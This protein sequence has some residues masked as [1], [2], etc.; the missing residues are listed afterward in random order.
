MEYYQYFRLEGPPF[1]PASPDGAVYFSPTHLQGLATLEAGLT[2]E[3][4]G[5]TLLTGEAGIGKTTL[6]Y[7]LLQRDYKRVRIAH[8]D[9]PKLSFLEILRVI[10]TQLNLYSAG[11]TKLDYLKVL[12]HLLELHGKEERIAIVVDESQ[13]LSDDILEELRLLS[14][15][16]QRNDRCLLQLIL[17]GQPE[18]AERLKKPELRQLNQRISSRGVLKPLNT[19][20]AIMYVECRLSVQGSKCSAIFEPRALNHL[21]RRS[22]GI[23]RKINMLCHSAMLAA[24][25]AGERKVSSRTAKKT[26]AEYHDSVG[27]TNRKSGTR[28][29]VMPALIVGTALAS[30]LLLG[31]VYPNVWSDW[32]LHHTV[33]FGRTNEQ[34]V[35]PASRATGH[36]KASGI[37]REA[38]AATSLTPHPVESRAS[39][40]PRA[41]APAAPKSDVAEPATAPKMP[42]VPTAPA[43]AAL[44]A[45]IQKQTGVPAASEQRSQITVRDGDTLEK[46]TIRYFGSK[47]GINELIEANPQL[48]N[49]NQLSVGQI[50]YLPPG[51]TPKASHDRTAT[52]RPVPNAEDS[53]ER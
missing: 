44:S 30:L 8:I 31:F 10:L 2:G 27:I 6:I 32:L 47:S 42:I 34:T 25:Y 38:K 5:L 11:S 21:L 16:G 26:A 37:R 28:R 29:L 46:I 14:N 15:R 22:D 45:G 41:A 19:A 50:I 12:D 1:Q 3:L 36:R 53:P 49:I 51:I 17:V 33:S 4:S 40:A 13:V 23:P 43:A 18:L 52:A 48:T 39:L 20:E 24:F 9:D 35:R 7:S